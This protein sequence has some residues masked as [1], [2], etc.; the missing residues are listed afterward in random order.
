MFFSG[1]VINNKKTNERFNLL[2]SERRT[3]VV[4][5]FVAKNEISTTKKDIGYRI[6][7]LYDYSSAFVTDV[8]RARVHPSFQ[9]RVDARKRDNKCFRK[10]IL[11]NKTSV[12]KK[13]DKLPIQSFS[14]DHYV[15]TRSR[16]YS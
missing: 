16:V 7:V 10:L 11:H 1:F 2:R 4:V 3:V 12:R 5:V 15:L 9:R 14:Y 6:M 8:G 13:Q